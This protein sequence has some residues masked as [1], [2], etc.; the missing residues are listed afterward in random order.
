MRYLNFN[1]LNNGASLKSSIDDAALSDFNRKR[2]NFY[3]ELD[4]FFKKNPELQSQ[5][6]T[7]NMCIK[8]TTV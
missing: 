6:F 5:P 4:K 8:L 2:L 7:A 3:K 1:K